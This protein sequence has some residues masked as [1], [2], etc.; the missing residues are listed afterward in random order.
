MAISQIPLAKFSTRNSLVC[1][2]IY[3]YIKQTSTGVHC[4][5]KGGCMAMLIAKLWGGGG[6]GN[7]ICPGG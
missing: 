2:C 6:G 7:E 4:F 1:T 5:F 3:M